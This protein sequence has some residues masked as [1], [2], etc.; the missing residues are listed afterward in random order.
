MTKTKIILAS[1]SPRRREILENAGYEPELLP[2]EADESSVKYNGDPCEYVKAL[3]K[4]KNDAAYKSCTAKEGIILSADTVVV[5]TDAKTPLGKPH[6]VEEAEKII[7]SLSGKPHKVV[8]GVMLRDIQ[9]GNTSVFAEETEVEFRE[10]LSD[11]IKSY[12]ATSEPYD[13]A[14]AYGIQGSACV[15]VR[16]IIG[17]YYNVVGLPICRVHEELCRLENMP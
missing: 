14:G 6:S 17:D 7:K 5:S 1:A 11:E 4:L 8:T 10:L 16:R 2:A 13:K 3:A 12:C 15:F 9:S